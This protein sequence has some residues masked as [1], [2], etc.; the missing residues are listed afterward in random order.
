MPTGYTHEGCRIQQLDDPTLVPKADPSLVCKLLKSLYGLKQ[1]P[2]LWFNKLSSTLLQMGFLQSKSDHNLFTKT[3][4][5]TITLILGYVDDLLICGN[6]VSEIEKLQHMLSQKFHMK[7]LGQLHYFLGIEI[8]RSPDG[9][10]L[11]QQKYVTDILKEYGMLN[12]KPLQLPMDSHLKLTQDKGVPLPDSTS[13]QRLLGKLIYLSITRPDIMFTVQ[14][15]TQFMQ[16]PT[17]VHMQAAKRLLRY[18]SGT[19]TQGILLA[20]H[21]AA[22]LT[23]YCDSDWASC[24]TTRRSTSGYCIF[25]GESPI[26]WKTKKQNVVARSSTEVEYRSMALTT[27][28]VTWISALLKDLGLKNI[29]PAVLKCDNQAAIAIAA[30]PILHEKTKHVDIDCHY[31][32][33]Q[34]KAGVIQTEHVSSSDQ[35]VNVMTK[36]L[37]VKLHTKHITKLGSS[38]VV[39]SPP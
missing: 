25:L 17:S 1:A 35:V 22:K 27:C 7:N 21:S 32:R 6:S 16:S 26:S 19:T 11:S 39:P 30:N 3:S 9:F 20:S 24:P 36:V 12:V 14:L 5:S 38:P 28:E 8:H 29:P 23:A 13:Y 18:L 4:D 2:R 15:L 31:M 37:P 33:D 34:L 10:F